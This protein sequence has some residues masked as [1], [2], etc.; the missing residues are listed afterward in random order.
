MDFGKIEEFWLYHFSYAS[1]EEYGQVS[2]LRMVNTDERIDCCFI[3]GKA[4]VTN[5][6]VSKSGKFL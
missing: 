5:S 4:R 1:E 6:T 3:A 2:Y